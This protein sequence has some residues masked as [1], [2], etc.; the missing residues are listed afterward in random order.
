MGSL[1]P[2]AELLR[3]E[4]RA[5]GVPPDLV[6]AV[7]LQESGADPWAM[8]YEPAFYQRYVAALPRLSGTERTA[9][10]ISWG[11]MQLMGQVAREE[12]FDGIWLSE[13]CD[14]R[15]G[16]RW[17][18]RH[19]RRCIDR[20]PDIADAVAAYNAGSPRKEENGKYVN[21]EYVDAVLGRRAALG[22]EWRA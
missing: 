17:G 19:L 7:V 11:L 14:P 12:G 4:A 1:A 13:L 2:I 15:A 9:R 16:L 3:A 6:A 22:P 18:C 21:Q 8:R 10:A 20:W 5:A